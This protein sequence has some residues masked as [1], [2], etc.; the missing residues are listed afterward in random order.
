VNVTRNFIIGLDLGQAQDYTAT[1]IIEMV[2]EGG[3]WDY[4]VGQLERVRGMPYPDV[5]TRIESIATGLWELSGDYPQA[6]QPPALVIDATGVGKPVFDMFEHVRVLKGWVKPVGILI[7]GGDR[8][9][10]EGRIYRTP[11]R[12]LVAV[13]QVLL[14]ND[15]LKIAKVDLRDTLKQEMLNLRQKIDPETA[16]DSYSAWRERDHDDLVL[17]VALACWYGEIKLR[18]QHQSPLQSANRLVKRN[19]FVRGI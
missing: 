12:D 9:T 15:R 7:H 18:K 2:K 5:V 11:K 1:S 17:A 19:L 14:Q 16:H 13:L 8:V 10:N 3:T 6:R 4:H